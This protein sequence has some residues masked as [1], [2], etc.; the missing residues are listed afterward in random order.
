M[1]YDAA[2]A[3]R[4]YD[5]PMPLMLPLMPDIFAI[6]LTPIYDA[7]RHFHC[8]L[9]PMP[10][11]YAFDVTPPLRFSSPFSRFRRLRGLMLLFFTPPMLSR[12]AAFQL[13][14]ADYFCLFDFLLP[15]ACCYYF[16]FTP[17]F[18]CFIIYAYV[19]PELIFL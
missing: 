9:M 4:C 17:L 8:F 1:I 19:M 13:T 3:L 14:D 10:M 2:T 16:H 18:L 12:Y 6:L 5:A 7:T 11:R 15:F